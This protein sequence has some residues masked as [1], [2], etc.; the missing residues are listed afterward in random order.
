MIKWLK[1]NNNVRVLYI[2]PIIISLILTSLLFSLFYRKVS[3]D[4]EIIYQ[5]KVNAID[6]IANTINYAEEAGVWYT[7]RELSL[8]HIN[9][10]MRDLDSQEFIIAMLFDDSLNQLSGAADVPDPTKQEEFIQAV[11]NN[12]S[13]EVQY[14]Y[15]VKQSIK[16]YFRW[17]PDAACPSEKVLMVVAVDPAQFDSQISEFG[18]ITAMI[19]GA[20]FIL[21]Y[22]FVMIIVWQRKQLVECLGCKK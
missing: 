17:V 22:L 13:G 6:S 21:Q 10:E 8:G 4:I 1:I 2:A 9:M 16:M 18:L 20:M 7:D 15:S 19:F 11:S 3:N 12:E 14:Q 5:I